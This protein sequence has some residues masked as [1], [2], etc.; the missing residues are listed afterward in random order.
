MA[1]RLPE[2][3]SVMAFDFGVKR[4]GVATGN[5]TLGLATPLTTIHAESNA[6]RLDAVAALVT[7]WQP[8]QFVVGQPRHADGAPH[9]IAHLAKKFGNRLTERFKLAVDYVDETLSSHEAAAVLTA[10]GVTGIAQKQFLDQEAAAVLL[11]SWLDHY[12]SQPA[13]AA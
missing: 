10:R 13:H 9:E 6:D 3:A 7:E 2:H 4:I 8:Q 11:Q 5:V 12:R 1:A